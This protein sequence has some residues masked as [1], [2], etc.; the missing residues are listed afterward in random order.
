M[1]AADMHHR[2]AEFREIFTRS[3]ADLKTFIGHEK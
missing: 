3:L 1:A 2:T